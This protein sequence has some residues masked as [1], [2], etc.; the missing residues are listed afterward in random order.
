ML[1]HHR[2]LPRALVCDHSLF[3]LISSVIRSKIAEFSI[4][5]EREARFERAVGSLIFGVINLSYTR[6]VSVFR[7]GCVIFAGIKIALLFYL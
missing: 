1:V 7:A 4:L 3:R 2:R 6:Q 5:F